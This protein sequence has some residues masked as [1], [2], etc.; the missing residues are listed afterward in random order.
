[1][2]HSFYFIGGSFSIRVHAID[3]GSFVQVMVI[4]PE[5]QFTAKTGPEPIWSGWLDEVFQT[6]PVLS[7]G[8]PVVLYE[9]T[10]TKV[11]KP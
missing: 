6:I 10:T 2:R 8:K 9:T 11:T 1:M 7:N 4:M 5:G 3:R